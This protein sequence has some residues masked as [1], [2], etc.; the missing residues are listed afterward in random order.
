MLSLQLWS[1]GIELL[2]YWRKS[3]GAQLG[4]PGLTGIW[5]KLASFLANLAVLFSL[6][7][8]LVAVGSCCSG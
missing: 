8:V 3:S 6:L 7:W 5:E 4:N 1:C 2:Q